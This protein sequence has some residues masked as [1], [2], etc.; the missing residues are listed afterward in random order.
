[1]PLDFA[2]ASMSTSNEWVCYTCFDYHRRCATTLH[3]PSG[4]R[5]G[6]PPH[7]GTFA[8]CIEPCIRGYTS[9]QRTYN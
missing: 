3:I 2:S 6:G 9:L 5:Q 8:L 1:M 4:M 7:L